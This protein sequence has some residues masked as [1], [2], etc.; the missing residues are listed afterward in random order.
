MESFVVT[1]R[2]DIMAQHSKSAQQKSELLDL[3]RK[4]GTVEDYESKVASV[5]AEYQGSL[6]NLNAQ[7][8]AIADQN[9]TQSE[10]RLVKLF[11]ELRALDDKVKDERIALLE[12]N[13]S[14]VKTENQNIARQ[15][16]AILGEE[17]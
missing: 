4:Y 7:Y 3:L 16:I 2:E 9:L 12:K 15:I 17:Q 1:F 10:I 8:K 5:K 14:D 6:D 11:R 13:L